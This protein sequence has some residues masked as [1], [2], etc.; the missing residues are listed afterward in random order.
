MLKTVLDKRHS[1][2]GIGTLEVLGIVM[3]AVILVSGILVVQNKYPDKIS[4]AFCQF[5]AAVGYGG[6]CEDGASTADGGDDGEVDHSFPPKD[7]K[8]VV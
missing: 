1:E 5:G 4:N 7:R 8:S 6:D 3:T 2:R